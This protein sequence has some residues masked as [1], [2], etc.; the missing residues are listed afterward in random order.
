MGEGCVCLEAAAWLRGGLEPR[1]LAAP[2]SHQKATFPGDPVCVVGPSLQGGKSKNSSPPA[3]P[4]QPLPLS[5]GH[6]RVSRLGGTEGLAV[7]HADLTL[8]LLGTISST[9]VIT[10]ISRSLT[11][12]PTVS[13]P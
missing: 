4:P 8:P 10:P 13:L 12:G 2:L 1:P 11:L 6:R 7:T 3:P 5:S 9:A